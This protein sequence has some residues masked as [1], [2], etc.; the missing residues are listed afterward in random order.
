MVSAPLG[1]T[2]CSWQEGRK[3]KS[4]A[5]WLCN[6]LS[7][8]DALASFG[9]VHSSAVAECCCSPSDV[10][11]WKRELS[12]WIAAMHAIHVQCKIR[13][14]FVLMER[15]GIDLVVHSVYHIYIV[16]SN[17]DADRRKP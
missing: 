13:V 15:R 1:D 10:R 17:N 3:A 16:I 2:L 7:W 14:L 11:G 5:I 6:E 9:E 8:K 4:I 12:C